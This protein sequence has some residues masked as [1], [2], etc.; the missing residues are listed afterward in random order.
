MRKIPLS[1]AES[2]AIGTVSNVFNDTMNRSRKLEQDA[3][4]YRNEML[5]KILREN[6]DL[7]HLVLPNGAVKEFDVEFSNGLP[8]NVIL[9]DSDS[10]E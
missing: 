4:A 8:I 10:S 6:K 2:V 1:A 5:G 9:K 3:V 7:N